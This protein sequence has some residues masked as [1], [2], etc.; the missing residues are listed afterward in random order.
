[1]NALDNEMTDVAE[2]KTEACFHF[3]TVMMSIVCVLLIALGEC[4]VSSLHKQNIR[5]CVFGSR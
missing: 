2:W 5:F 3:D 1:M 4:M